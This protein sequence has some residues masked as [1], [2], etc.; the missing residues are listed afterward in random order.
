MIEQLFLIIVLGLCS[1]RIARFFVDDKLIGMGPDS[2]SWLSTKVDKFAY[3]E[4]GAD[5]N[6]LRCKIGDLATCQ[7]CFGFWV[8]MCSYALWT[9]SLPWQPGQ[10]FQQWW[11]MVFAIAGV[12][13]FI[14]SRMN[15]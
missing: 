1:Y 9:W 14:G 7:F 11:M 3:T 15:A 5:R 12:Q 8:S 6:F 13:A 10:Q 4:D 2:G